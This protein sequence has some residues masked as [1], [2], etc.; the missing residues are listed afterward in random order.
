MS[1]ADHPK[2]DVSVRKHLGPGRISFL[3]L[4]LRSTMRY[5]HQRGLPYPVLFEWV[6]TPPGAANLAGSRKWGRGSESLFLSG[7]GDRARVFE[8]TVVVIYRRQA[9]VN[10]P[11]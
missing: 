1:T 11:G 5:T 9:D 2:T 7:L 3:W 4:S 10:Q 8:K 6:T